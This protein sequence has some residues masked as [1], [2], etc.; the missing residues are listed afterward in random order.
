M[1]SS[2]ILW[3]SM[4]MKALDRM[5]ASRPAFSSPPDPIA[6]FVYMAVRECEYDLKP[7]RIE[8]AG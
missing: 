5:V 4:N 8:L 7:R 6:V 1:D 2:V 3:S